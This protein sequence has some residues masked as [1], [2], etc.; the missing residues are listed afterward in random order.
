[1]KKVTI[2]VTSF[3]ASV[4]GS[5]GQWRQ[6]E[7]TEGCYL[8]ACFPHPLIKSLAKASSFYKNYGH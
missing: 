4:P 8:H 3:M 1:M 6:K 7:S 2:F 5:D